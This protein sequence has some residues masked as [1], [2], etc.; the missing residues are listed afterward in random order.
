VTV[1]SGSRRIRR[2]SPGK[3]LRARL[4]R[5][6]VLPRPSKI[7]HLLRARDV[8]FT[9]ENAIELFTDGRA[10]LDAMLAAI[11]DAKKRIHLETYILRADATGRRFL[12]A[13]AERARAGVEVRLLYDGIGSLGL[14]SGELDGL[15]AAG[16]DVVVFN[17][18]ARF[19]PRWVPRRR[20]HRKILIVDGEIAFTGGLNIGDEYFEGAQVGAG[21]EPWRDAHV[22][23]AGPAVMMLEAVFLE[24][25]F[26]ADG[27]D[28]PWTSALDL[29]P[30]AAGGESVG[31]LAD[32]PSYHR[33][34]TRELLIEVLGRTERQARFA[35]P[36]LIPGRPLRN[37]LMAAASRGVEV[38]IL[39]A[40]YIDHPVVR[41][42]TFAKLPELLATGIRVYEYERSMMHAKV[43]VFD[44]DWA[45]LG[46][47]NLDRQ[48]LQ[49][50][51]EV[52]LVVERG[53][54]PRR[55]SSMLS[56]D[57]GAS[58]EVTAACIAQRSRWLRLRDRIAAALFKLGG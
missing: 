58:R 17:P 45:I 49:H 38:T 50:S 34:R 6:G 56:E 32:G 52:N 15:R 42:A 51:Y 44:D 41:W 16:A 2:R 28:C 40:G 55:L 12:D 23:I 19:Y 8:R 26:R 13:M 1:G 20:D 24:S 46:T 30:S 33:R 36:Y 54:L 31:V 10:G 25:W 35:T 39:I 4:R 9:H 27:P 3:G 48:S 11:A 18:I 57:I 14:G 37:A 21:R 22:R 53:E 29:T 7:R 47:S 43:A 5:H